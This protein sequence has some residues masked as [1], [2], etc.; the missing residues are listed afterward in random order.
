MT[1]TKNKFLGVMFALLMLPLVFMFTACGV[2]VNGKTYTYDRQEAYF[3]EDATNAQIKA[4][5]DDLE[6]AYTE[7]GDG[8]LE[9]VDEVKQAIIEAF[10]ADQDAGEG[11]YTFGKDQV[12]A[13]FDGYAFT[14]TYKLKGKKITVTTSMGPYTTT[15]VYKVIDNKTIVMSSLDNPGYFPEGIIYNAYFTVK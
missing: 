4:A 13:S 15:Q 3:A 2:S 5:A 12:T 14:G 1:T 8:N 11:G 9:N 10:L 7:D 6:V